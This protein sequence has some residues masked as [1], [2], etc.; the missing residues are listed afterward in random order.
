MTVGL[1]SELE[2]SIVNSGIANMK[3]AC[4]IIQPV[5][6]L[7]NP[8]AVFNVNPARSGSAGFDSLL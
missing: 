2:Y 7:C 8:L 5:L 1:F 4:P 3:E 6:D